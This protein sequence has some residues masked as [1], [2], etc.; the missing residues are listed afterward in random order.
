VDCAHRGERGCK[1][2]LLQCI[3][4]AAS[5]PDRAN[6][7]ADVRSLVDVRNPGEPAKIIAE[8]T[9][10]ERGHA[11][12]EYPGLSPRPDKPPI[13]KS[14]LRIEPGWRVFQGSSEW[15]FPGGE[16]GADPLREASARGLRSWFVAGYGVARELPRLPPD[17]ELDPVLVRLESLF[18]KSG[19]IAT[20]FR[21]L[22]DGDRATLFAALMIGALHSKGILPTSHPSIGLTI[23]AQ[24]E[25]QHY[26]HVVGRTALAG[27]SALRKHAGSANDPDS[28]AEPGFAGRCVRMACS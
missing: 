13:L 12:R 10:G 24:G 2:A 7:L 25:R 18:G 26:Q 5:G 15:I 1:T 16:A 14:T 21:D 11:R 23:R 28:S 9:F 19:P 20:S 22:L 8:F 3:A 17:R 6:Q 27:V 4:L